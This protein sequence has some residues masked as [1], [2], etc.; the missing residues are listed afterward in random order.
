MNHSSPKQPDHD[1]I[2]PLSVDELRTIFENSLDRQPQPHW[3]PSAAAEAA[4]TSAA[5][6]PALDLSEL[7]ALD[8][9]A[10]LDR[11][12]HAILRRA[13]DEAGTGHYLS[14]LTSGESRIKI[15]GELR[16]SVEGR[17]VGC[18]VP[19]LR[20]R[21]LI[22]RLYRL[23]ILGRLIRTATALVALPGLMRDVV[24]LAI[25][26]RT[27]R[28]QVEQAD[29]ADQAQAQAHQALETRIRA[30]TDYTERAVDRAQKARHHHARRLDELA[31]RLDRLAGRL[32]EEPWAD[33]LLSLAERSDDSFAD[34]AEQLRHLAHEVAQDAR[35]RQL[36]SALAETF[37]AFREEL[38]WSGDGPALAQRL[39]GLLTEH[40]NLG[41]LAI[42]TSEE[43][44]VGLRDQEWRLSMLLEET[45]RWMA[46]GIEAEA[47]AKLED[48][49]DRLLD[50][51]YLEFEDRFRGSRAD[52]K[53][54]QQVYLGLLQEVGAGQ[55]GRPIVDVGSGRGELLEL[56]GEAGLEARGVDLNQSMVALCLHAGL[57]CVLDDA[58]SY[59]SKLDAGSLG[60]V[61]GFHI[62]EHLPFATF[63]ALLDAS[64]R[65][66]APGGIVIFETPN[67]ANLLVASRWFHLDPTHRN[68][69]PAEMV[70]MIAE[71]RG[72]VQVG[73]RELHPM[74]QRFAAK[75]DVLA[76]QLD[77]MFH[78]PQDY[79]L[80]ARKA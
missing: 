37:A 77:A 10:F 8:D 54:R 18:T 59:L 50:P 56:L 31:E 35:D 20:R 66:L 33:P 72:F 23:P 2:R 75:D 24:R 27:L 45:R 44:R 7:A 55:S 19:G 49:Q 58:V 69:L 14:A 60:A 36:I 74:P 4:P 6:A 5:L 73:I 15:L 17:A 61:T 52:I 30:W 9:Q 29:H 16:Y 38:G 68:P 25:E 32:D 28:T 3:Q 64:L 1:P 53:Q 80:I 11:A 71:A 47:P 78:G 51:L 22:H 79:A 65:A 76:A 34:Q 12:Y 57:S 43:T 46:H 21:F 26:L 40:R 39:T 67:P 70:S 41:R 48:V 13:P 63:V 42:T 62:I